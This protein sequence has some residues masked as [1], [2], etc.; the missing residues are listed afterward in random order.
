MANINFRGKDRLLNLLGRLTAPKDHIIK[1]KNFPTPKAIFKL[2][3][4]WGNELHLM[5]FKFNNV[6]RDELL[7]LKRYGPVGGN[8]FDIGANIGTFSVF[9]YYELLKPSCKIFAFEPVQ[10]IF[11]RCYENIQINNMGQSTVLESYA[12]HDKSGFE[13]IFIGKN[14][15]RVSGLSSIVATDLPTKDIVGITVPAITLDEYCKKNSINDVSLIKID[16]EG[17]EINVL[18]GARNIIKRDSPCVFFEV[19]QQNFNGDFK[20][21]LTIFQDF[22]KPL[23]YA[24]YFQNGLTKQPIEEAL[25]SGIIKTGNWWAEKIQG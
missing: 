14:L 12:V 24:L 4:H 21:S 6:S 22:F 23:N 17:S 20:N 7:F 1:I 16:T 13:K 25:N 11:K 19:N 18:R 8:F 15:Q 10:E 3:Y 5:F 2:N 9:L